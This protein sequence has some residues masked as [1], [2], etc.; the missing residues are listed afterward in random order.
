MN[1]ELAKR[2]RRFGE[3]V[4][5]AAVAAGAPGAGAPGGPRADPETA[6]RANPLADSDELDDLEPVVALTDWRH[7]HFR[8]VVAAAAALV[9][10][11]AGAVF[12][13]RI[14][15]SPDAGS[16]ASTDLPG[17]VVDSSESST[18][19]ESKVTVARTS[20]SAPP[21]APAVTTSVTAGST[22]SS[23]TSTTSTTETPTTTR[24][25]TSSQD[26]PRYTF[27]S[28]YP[29]KLCNRGAAVRA[30]QERLGVDAD[31]FFGPSTRQAVRDFQGDNGLD[32]DG[33]VGPDT[34]A[35][36]G[37]AVVGTDA[38]GDGIID[39]NEMG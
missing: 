25:T 26:C 37:I 15:G 14:S 12:T 38:D 11:V 19:S 2:L 23:T 28:E 27:N 1:P 31:G 20:T 29:L 35:A 10:V 3:T 34:W 33:L 17:V 8:K 6:V 36:L 4:D 18:T 13:A 22:T 39:P 16:A 21:V 7:R 5:Q 32:V 24:P 30:V 9:V